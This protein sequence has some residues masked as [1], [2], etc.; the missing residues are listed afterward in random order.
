MAAEV[1]GVDTVAVD[2]GGSGLVPGTGVVTGAVDEDEWW[3]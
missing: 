2:E 3:L 1:G